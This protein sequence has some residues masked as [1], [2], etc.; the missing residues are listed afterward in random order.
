[1]KWM[2]YVVILIPVVVIAIAVVSSVNRFSLAFENTNRVGYGD[3]QVVQGD[4]I[5]KSLS[6]IHKAKI[7]TRYTC[8]GKDVN[9]PLR[10]YNIP[11]E[12]ESLALV[13]VDPD[14]SSG[15]FT[16][17]VVW[18]IDPDTESIGEGRL[19]KGAIE[20]VNDFGNRRYN[21]PCPGNAKHRYFFTI[22][23]LDSELDIPEHSTYEDLIDELED[24]TIAQVGLVGI[25][26]D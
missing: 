21:G 20:G 10:I 13:V 25:F 26:N 2:L 16:H 15:N 1:M 3:Y 24:N 23:A 18:N 12:T 6:F 8:E 17:W 9:P 14:A 4:F 5:M 22:Y 11:E 19:P 7:P